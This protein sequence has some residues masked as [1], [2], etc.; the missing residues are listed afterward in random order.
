MCN[1]NCD[2]GR[3][4]SCATEESFLADGLFTLGF[5]LTML[6]FGGILGFIAGSM[7]K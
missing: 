7:M 3:D 1:G 4:C 2:Q 5:A 6:A